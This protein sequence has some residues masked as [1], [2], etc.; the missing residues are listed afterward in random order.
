MK[1]IF[2]FT[3]ALSAA[4]SNVGYGQQLLPDQNP[5]HAVSRDY[6]MENYRDLT[7]TQGQTSQQ[8]YTAFDWTTHKANQKQQRIDR[9]Y[10]LKQMRYQSRYF[11][12]NAMSPFNY[13]PNGYYNPYYTPYYSPFLYGAGVYSFFF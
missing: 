5:N 9:R 11:C 13:G 4:A 1:N 8:T 2:L 10:E 6:Y 12:N 3:L 7:A